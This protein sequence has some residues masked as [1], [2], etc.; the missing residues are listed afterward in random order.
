[1]P[2][3]TVDIRE[4]RIS[5]EIISFKAVSQTGVVIEA[6][7][8][9]NEFSSYEDF[10][11]WLISQPHTKVVENNYRKRLIITFHTEV[12][13]TRILDDLI[14][15]NLPEEVSLDEIES[16]PN[17]ASWNVTQAKDWI[18]TNVTNLA[19]AKEALKQMAEMIIL[20]RDTVIGMRRNIQ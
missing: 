5:G 7:V 16:I 13:G 3:T 20:L 14:V 8:N 2:Q 10:A 19:T 18:E 11:K 9:L 17:W 6:E 12:D 1:M 4:T 15:S